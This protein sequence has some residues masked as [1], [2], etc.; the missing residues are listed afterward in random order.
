MTIKLSYE[1]FINYI[2]ASI[3]G[4]FA[5]LFFKNIDLILS[6]INDF[7]KRYQIKT[8]D[9]I[10]VKISD[11]FNLN[12]IFT[13]DN[14]S[15]YIDRKSKTSKNE[16]KVFEK[17][18]LPSLIYQDSNLNV[19]PFQINNP[20]FITQKAVIGPTLIIERNNKNPDSLNNK[21]ILI[22]GAD[23][24][25]DWIFAH[26]IKGLITMF[27]GANSHMS[28]RCS[29]FNIPAAIDVAKFYLKILR[30]RLLVRL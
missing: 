9:L 12:N 20:N 10:N 27:G 30:L 15:E 21:I 28:I 25:Y 17:I 14:I 29:E 22:E 3:Q 6:L 13:F 23:P 24:G 26:K 5:S 8:E 7:G 18:K 2:I 16:R 11:Y 4:E 19:I 1:T